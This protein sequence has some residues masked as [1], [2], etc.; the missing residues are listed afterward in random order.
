MLPEIDNF[1]LDMNGIIHNCTHPGDQDVSKSLSQREMMLAIF[2]YIDRCVSEIVK[3]KKLL[4][5]AIDGVAPRAKLNQQRARRFRS[6]Q[7]REESIIKA[8]QRGETVDEANMFDSN[9]ITPGT[10]FMDTVCIHIRWF[11]KKKVKEDPLWRDLEIIFSGGDV[12][13]EGEHKIMAYIRDA[14]AKPDYE[15]NLRHCMYGQDADLIMLGLCT[16]EPH[17]MLLREV[18]NFGSGVGGKSVRQT[19]IRQ[20]R[21]AQFQLLHLSVLREYIEVD[22]ARDLTRSQVMLYLHLAI[23][24]ESD[25]LSL[26]PS[27]SSCN[28]T[29][30][31]PPHTHTQVAVALDKERLID[32]FVFM[33]FLVGN[34]FLPHLPT[35]DISEH[36]FDTLFDAYKTLFQEDPGY[37]VSQGSIGDLRRLERFFELVGAK[38]EEILVARDNDIRQF[39]AKARKHAAH[40]GPS[41]DEIEENEAAL[42]RA[43]QD[44]I[45]EALGRDA[46]GDEVMRELRTG[47]FL[48]VPAGGRR[49]EMK[50]KTSGEEEEEEEEEGEVVPAKDYR[51]RYYFEKFR[52]LPGVQQTEIFL[53]ELMASYL[54]G[55]LW[56]LAYYSKGCISWTWYFPYHYG[57][58]LQDMKGLATMSEKITFDLGAPFQP[59]Q[60]LLGCLPPGSRKLLPRSYQWLMTSKDS[61]VIEY[62]PEEFGI[63]MNGKRNPWEA[64]TLL[65]FIDE[66]RL[67]EAEATH[68][69]QEELT[70]SEKARNRFGTITQCIFNPNETSTYFSCNPEIGLPDITN[71]QSTFTQNASDLTPGQFFVPEVVK[72]TISPYPG[73]PSL[74]ALQIKRVEVEMLKLNIFGSESKY[75]SMALEVLPVVFEEGMDPAILQSLIG[76]SVYVNYPMSHE[77]KV[78]AVNTKSFEYR[79]DN[80]SGEAVYSEFDRKR[81]EKWL[82]DAQDDTLK[83]ALRFPLSLSFFRHIFFH[84]DLNYRSFTSG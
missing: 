59:F 6:A 5:L 77:A 55:L 23:V 47:P 44:A 25:H 67:L 32:D 50:K 33:T 56:C 75:K 4:Y 58:M 9:C 68:C 1:Y 48:P 3:P 35:L 43:Y 84:N 29:F 49:R 22:I 8:K 83:Y 70:S 18:I 11:I 26:L 52:V 41:L 46:E 64:V 69:P 19:V 73:F 31:Y 37:L 20:T 17:F 63:D 65:P 76:R 81:T 14:R 24:R 71:S 42:E 74:S 40:T 53:G 12:P 51:G 36:A 62:Y 28:Q 78:V 61:P 13:G 60:Q 79:L 54:E 10:E 27:I 34:D 39:S 72:G 16:H 7:D 21:E 82:S 45:Q 66:V 2:R 30:P 57:P 80:I 15:P 38:E